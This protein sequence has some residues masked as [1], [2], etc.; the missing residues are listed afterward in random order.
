MVRADDPAIKN[1]LLCA[2]SPALRDGY[3][4]QVDDGIRTCQALRRR[5]ACENVP[6]RTAERTHR[7]TITRKRLDEIPSNE[8]R[9][10]G[11]GN[12]HV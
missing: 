11:N 9:R 3:A 12:V 7:M 4:S 6:C 8:S 1:L 5:F 10:S 2:P